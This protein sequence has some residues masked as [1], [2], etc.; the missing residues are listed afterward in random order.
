MTPKISILVPVYNVA[1]Y[2]ERCAHSLFQQTLDSIEFVFVDDASPDDSIAL[3]E[4]VVEEYP[5]RKMQVNIIRHPVNKGIGATRNTLLNAATGEYL[6]W[7]DSD[8]FLDIKAAEFLYHK[9]VAEG[10][11]IVTTDIYYSYR[12]ESD[13]LAVEQSLPADSFKYI[14]ALA[15]RE[16]RAALWGTLSKRSLWTDHQVKMAEGVNFGEDYF[17]TVRLFYFAR[18]I[19]VVNQPLYYYNQSNLGSY[20]SGCK[21]VLHFDSMI[22]LFQLLEEFFVQN[23]DL[24]RY[25][26]Y[27]AKARLMERSAYLLHTTAA[28]RRKYA[29]LF[30][31]VEKRHP[32]IKLPFSAW[33]RFL[34]RVITSR[35]YFAGDILIVVAKV[36]RRYLGVKF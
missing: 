27:L 18:K 8:D 35:Y 14:E 3:L 4:K 1:A 34:L 13:V 36:L 5:H 23:D 29:I 33:Q 7:V 16:A 32:E 17:A 2:I 6:M 25:E 12:E 20:S 26:L 22:R 11:D 21:Q 19:E 30:A 24:P 10:A 15:F 9:A 31:D 28:S